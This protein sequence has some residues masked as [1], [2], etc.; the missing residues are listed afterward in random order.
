MSDDIK[1]TFDNEQ[2]IKTSLDLG[3]IQYGQLEIGTTTTGEAGTKASV[4]N[5]GSSA[6]AILNFVIP[7]GDSGPTGPQGPKGDTG[8][9]GPQ[10]PAG[11]QGEAGPQGPQGPQGE[12]G[13][14]GVDGIDGVDGTDAVY[15]SAIE[16]TGDD[17]KKVWLQKTKN[18]FNSA[19]QIDGVRLNSTNGSLETYTGRTTSDFIKVNPNTDYIFSI[20][21]VATD[22]N[23]YEY[24]NDGSFIKSSVASTI[25][26]T[27]NTHYIRFYGSTNNLVN[28]QLEQGTTVTEY[29]ENVTSAIYTKNN[30]DEYEKFSETVAISS[31]QPTN[32]NGLWL[33]K[34]KNLFN[35]NNKLVVNGSP[36][37]SMVF[38]I[39][40]T[41]SSR[42]VIL[43]CEPNSTYTISKIVTTA[44]SV[45]SSEEFPVNNGTITVINT[46]H[47]AESITITTGENDKYLL[48]QYMH[49]GNDTLTENEILNSLQ[50]EQ[51]STATD[52]E[53]YKE[54]KIYTKNDNDVYEEF[55][56]ADEVKPTEDF[57]NKVTFNETPA[58]ISFLKNGNVIEIT[59]QG[60]AKTH[61]SNDILFILP[62]EC[63][64]T[65]DRYFPF[66]KNADAYGVAIVARDGNC[67]IN[68]INSTTAN[69]RIYF[70]VTYIV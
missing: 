47:N 43:R 25:R 18:L 31:H 8:A 26:T 38:V 11:P 32:Q 52:Y 41:K 14:D 24:K 68:Q 4:T 51:G 17:R 58:N 5:T 59:Y 48:I 3:S 61:K 56:N 21:G 34:G 22:T 27:E 19:T 42:S 29:E 65:K 55:L 54:K 60:E 15:I 70:T 13:V 16:P 10:G 12:A 35:K 7:K 28:V 49:T 50:V 66:V 1:I 33:Q 37:S 46:N 44:F 30:N 23:L 9:T 57:S 45:A 6:H 64:P 62:T 67:C 39:S 69:G 53:E 40:A 20:N 63:R 36:S 2:D